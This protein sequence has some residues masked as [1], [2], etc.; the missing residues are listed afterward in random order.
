MRAKRTPQHRRTGLEPAAR[1]RRFVRGGWSK[2]RYAIGIGG[3]K[4]GYRFGSPRGVYKPN[5]NRQSLI[6]TDARHGD[7]DGDG[8][9]ASVLGLGVGV[10][11]SD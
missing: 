4:L 11:V 6:D 9:A 3:G 8:V 10:G 1:A 7:R 2:I 5:A